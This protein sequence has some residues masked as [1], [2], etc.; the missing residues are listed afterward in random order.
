[1]YSKKWVGSVP[2]VVLRGSGVP[3]ACRIDLLERALRNRRTDKRAYTLLK[4]PT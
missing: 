2:I 3:A 1:M 4:A